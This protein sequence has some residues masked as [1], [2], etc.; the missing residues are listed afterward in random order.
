[1]YFSILVR[2]IFNQ[3]KLKRYL[4]TFFVIR[5]NLNNGTI[6]LDFFLVYK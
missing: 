3:A 4:F 1:M 6:L 5:L 2:F